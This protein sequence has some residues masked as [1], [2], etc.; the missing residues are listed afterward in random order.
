VAIDQVDDLQEA[1]LTFSRDVRIKV[2]PGG[3]EGTHPRFIAP[4]KVRPAHHGHQVG[5][6]R[7]GLR[8]HRQ[9]KVRVPVV[10]AEGQHVGRP[11]GERREQLARV[12]EQRDLVAR[13]PRLQ[14][15]ANV[16]DIEWNRVVRVP[17]IKVAEVRQVDAHG[18]RRRPYSAARLYCRRVTSLHRSLTIS[19]SVRATVDTLA[20]FDCPLRRC[21]K[22]VTPPRVTRRPCWRH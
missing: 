1:L 5:L 18:F 17:I 14:V 11:G 6:R 10:V 12:L 20:T 19:Q 9:V 7:L 21:R 15:R 22:R 16:P 4:M 13:P 3:E 2:G 8:Q